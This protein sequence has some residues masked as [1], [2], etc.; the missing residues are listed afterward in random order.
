MSEIQ[1]NSEFDDILGD[2][3][4]NELDISYLPINENQQDEME[5]LL[6][7]ASAP[8]NDASGTSRLAPHIGVYG[9][10]HM[11]PDLCQGSS[12]S[13]PPPPLKHW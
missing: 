12:P 6:G 8:T 11:G 7:V 5:M 9:N 3:N 13:L 10:R 2:M 1:E 4:F